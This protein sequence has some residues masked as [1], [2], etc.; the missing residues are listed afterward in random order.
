MQETD[1]NGWKGAGNEY[2]ENEE[3]DPDRSA[4]CNRVKKRSERAFSLFGMKLGVVSFL[5]F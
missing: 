3:Q 5:V 1:Y 2:Y 4:R